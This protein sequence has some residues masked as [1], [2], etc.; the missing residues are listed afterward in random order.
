[1][2]SSSRMSLWFI[3]TSAPVLLDTNTFLT[4]SQPCT[5]SSTILFRGIVLPPLTA[6]SAVTTTL[7][8]AEEEA[9]LHIIQT[10]Q[11]CLPVFFIHA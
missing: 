1:M 8:E 7:A 2:T 9:Q 11:K 10:I 6:S 4:H 5:A 3:G